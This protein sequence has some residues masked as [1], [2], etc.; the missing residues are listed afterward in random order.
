M[1]TALMLFFGIS[2]FFVGMR[3]SAFFS[4]SET[5]FYRLS[6]LQLSLQVQ[7]GDSVARR[8]R[9]FVQHPERFVATTLVGNN[10]A[11]YLTTLAIGICVTTVVTTSTGT[12]DIV[13]TILLTPVV[14]I[15]GELLP[16]SL[17]YRA[18]SS[19]L[20]KGVTQFSLAF[21]LFLPLSYPLI[22]VA[23]LVSRL[24][25]SSGRTLELVFGRT[26]LS[27]LLAAGH[28]EGILTRLQNQLAENV[29]LV[30]AQRVEEAMTPPSLCPGLNLSAT[31]EEIMA[32]ARSYERAYILLGENA[33]RCEWTH[34]VRVADII[35]PAQA[36]ADAIRPL[37][38]FAPDAARLDVLTE[39]FRGYA[40]HGA[41]V[42]QGRV[43][44]IVSRQT[45]VSQ[46]F[47]ESSPASDPVS[48]VA[49]G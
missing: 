41:V 44:G 7:N 6:T 39:L 1:T 47:R 35:S 25:D 21:Y 45:L 22:L 12:V 16:K 13:A 20:R 27:G 31:R 15:F 24:S 14:F 26:R 48:S 10:V 32:C 3:L 46:L 8:L 42:D 9:Y 4:G 18:P 34:V 29:L 37:P 49:V 43:V 11:N 2:L 19:L 36:M 5:G 28:R 30:A 40:A 38:V 17:Y 23:R 33:D